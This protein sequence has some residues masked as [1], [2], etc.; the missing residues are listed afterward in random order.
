MNIGIYFS[1][2]IISKKAI[3]FNFELHIKDIVVEC[4]YDHYSVENQHRDIQIIDLKQHI[5]IGSSEQQFDKPGLQFVPLF[6]EYTSEDS[7]YHSHSTQYL[8]QS[9]W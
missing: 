8:F 1:N 4:K 6:P 9:Y 3:H 7:S 5:H 2:L